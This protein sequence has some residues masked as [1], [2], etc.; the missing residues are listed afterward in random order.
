[1]PWRISDTIL[2]ID[3]LYIAL[4]FF[5]IWRNGKFTVYGFETIYDTLH[6][7]TGVELVRSVAKTL[8]FSKGRQQREL[9]EFT[10]RLKDIE[11]Y[12]RRYQS[13]AQRNPAFEPESPLD[14]RQNGLLIRELESLP[15]QVYE[16]VQ[17]LEEYRNEKYFGNV[18]IR[19]YL[20]AGAREGRYQVSREECIRRLG[21]CAASCG[22]CDQ[23]WG[24]AGLDDALGGPFMRMA[25]ERYSEAHCSIDCECCF[26]RRGFRS[27]ELDDQELEKEGDI[28][29]V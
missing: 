10:R 28:L 15:G 16:L 11:R 19:D 14:E 22:C 17:S 20:S 27:C 4:V 2:A 5:C 18:W 1:M 13:L 12:L 3:V 25:S 21:C 9:A 26:Q 23:P 24:E 29:W 6:G 8:S 7:P